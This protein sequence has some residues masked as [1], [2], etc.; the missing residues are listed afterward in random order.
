MRSLGVLP[1]ALAAALLGAP[2]AHAGPNDDYIA[3]IAQHGVLI[4]NNRDVVDG[5]ALGQSICQH[6]RDGS[7]PMAE[8]GVLKRNGSSF[9]QAVWIVRA[10]QNNLCP[11][12]AFDPGT[13]FGQP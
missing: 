2:A 11:D 10:A 7:S 8:R 12:T 6:V 4:V 3:T 9:D 13:T 5:I 1:V